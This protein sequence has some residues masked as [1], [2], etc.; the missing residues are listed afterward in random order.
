[1]LILAGI[2]WLLRGHQV[3]I[4]YDS[5]EPR[6]SVISLL[7]NMLQTSG[8]PHEAGD[9]P[10]GHLTVVQCDLRNKNEVHKTLEKLNVKKGSIPCVIAQDTVVNGS[11]FR[12]FCETMI[13]QCPNV[14]FWA[15]SNT[16]KD[17]PEGWTV[18]TFI[19][20]LTC[21]PYRGQR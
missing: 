16:Y 1:M 14:Y 2:M 20:V 6:D 17:V 13:S 18:K 11:H 9:P 12:S 4:L 3:Y 10:R 8:E 15:T 5:P 7:W 19:Q 21:P